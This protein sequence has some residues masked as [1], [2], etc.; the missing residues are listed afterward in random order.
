MTWSWWPAFAEGASTRAPDAYGAAGV[1]DRQ[2]AITDLTSARA[3]RAVA[4]AT[5]T[6]SLVEQTTRY[7]CGAAALAMILG[8]SSPEQ[9]ERDYLGRDTSISHAD[10]GI[11][12]GQI[13]VF[14]DEVQRVLFEVGIPTV[15]YVNRLRRQA[16][17]AWVCRIWD[18]ICVA[19]YSFLQYHR[20][21]GGVAMLTV[22]SLN[23]SRGEHWIVLAGEKIFDPSTSRKYQSYSEIA[24]VSDAILV[25]DRLVPSHEAVSEG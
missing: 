6:I 7:N 4:G 9:V 24:S 25:G 19:D 3:K 20:A 17:G 12:S 13:G 10:R 23:R 5:P 15:P 22:P 18:R 1:P 16:N 8:L 14:M 2:P 11:A 21:N